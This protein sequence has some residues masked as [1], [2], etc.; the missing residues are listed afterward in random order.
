MAVLFVGEGKSM[1]S[2]EIIF[3]AGFLVL[4]FLV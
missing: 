2:L 1:V 4:T 3:F